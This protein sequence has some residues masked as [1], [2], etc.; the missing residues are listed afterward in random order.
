MKTAKN[1]EIIGDEESR[2]DV[3][4]FFF[5]WAPCQH[6]V[7]HVILAKFIMWAGG[8]GARVVELEQEW[9]KCVMC[10]NTIGIKRLIDRNLILG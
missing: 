6:F 10:K 2:N 9:T 3:Y 8:N 5:R 4:I 7:L 1:L